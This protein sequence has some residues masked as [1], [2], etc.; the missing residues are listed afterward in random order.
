MNLYEITQDMRQLIAVLDEENINNDDL[1][2]AIELVEGAFVVKADKV[3]GYIKHLEHLAEAAKAEKDRLAELQKSREKKAETL[4]KYLQLNMQNAGYQK[5][6]SGAFTL[7]I[8]NNAES[9]KVD[10]ETAIPKEFW[11]IKTV[12]EVD[13]TKIKEVYKSSGVLPAGVRIERSQSL[14]IK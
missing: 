11:R 3:A 14:I 13:K 5:L 1:L 9:V 8:R 4:K 2:N 6:E 10:D 7:S 12:E